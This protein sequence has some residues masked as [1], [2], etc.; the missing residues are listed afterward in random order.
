MIVTTSTG[1]WYRSIQPGDEA[2]IWEACQFRSPR[3]TYA[4]CVNLVSQQLM[5][6][7]HGVNQLSAP[8]GSETRRLLALTT[9][10]VGLITLELAH[11]DER[12]A[13]EVSIDP[14]DLDFS[15][16]LWGDASTWVYALGLIDVIMTGYGMPA[17]PAGPVTDR[18]LTFTQ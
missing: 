6:D 3:P 15:D 14:V 10:P 1:L 8:T 18:Q 17:Q 16:A 7:A 9:R 13:A 5:D 12:N 2:A 4:E 11:D